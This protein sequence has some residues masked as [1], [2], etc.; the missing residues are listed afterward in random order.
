MLGRFAPPR[1]LIESRRLRKIARGAGAQEIFVIVIAPAH[2]RMAFALYSS[3]LGEVIEIRL[4]EGAEVEPVVAHPAVHHRTH[5]RR[6]FQR[7]MRI[8]QGHDHGEAFVG[9]PEHA[10]LAVGLGHVFHQPIDRVVGVGG[11]VCAGVIERPP[12]RARHQVF[13]FRSVLA[14]NILEHAD[15]AIAHEHLVTLRQSR[16]HI[17][18]SFPLGAARSVVGRAR[19]DDRRMARPAR[20][21]DHRVQLHAVAHGN[22][23]VALVVVVERGWRFE[24]GRDVWRFGRNLRMD[25]SPEDQ[26]HRY[27]EQT[28]LK[29]MWH[30]SAPVPGFG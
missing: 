10:N 17:R 22:H 30:G 15:V 29:S 28:A 3:L 26:Q 2:D 19:Q 12:E 18:R 9:T 21:D 11:F 7:R 27:H 20:N 6:D 8:D 16:E 13:A 4:P 25:G 5:R 23:H 24:F 1:Q 14:A